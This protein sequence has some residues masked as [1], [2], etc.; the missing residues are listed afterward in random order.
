VARDEE[1]SWASPIAVTRDGKTQVV[2]SGT[3]RIRS[4][5]LAT[6]EVLWAAGGLSSNV[7]CSPVSDGE[8]VWA[9]SSYESQ[10]LLAIDLARAKGDVTGTDVVPWV[11]RRA[12]PYV[13]SLLLLDGSLYFLHHYQGFLSRVEART[14]KEPARATRLE[15]LDDVYASPV[16]AAG[17]IY[18][19]DRSGVTAVLTPGTLELLAKNVLDDSFSAS[20]AFAGRELFLRGERALY[21]LAEE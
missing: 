7:V 14:G 19:T 15:G 8:F 12:T 1:T 16:A 21:C 2:V 18:V 6:G 17:R 11:R 13:P 5:D 4:Y 20:A 9:G 3:K 10:A